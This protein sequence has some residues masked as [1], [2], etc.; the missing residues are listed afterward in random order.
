ME[1]CD[2]LEVSVGDKEF[3]SNASSQGMLLLVVHGPEKSQNVVM[4]IPNGG[5]FSGYSNSLPTFSNNQIPE[6]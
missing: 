5:P 3:L 6:G 1:Y 2:F 4:D